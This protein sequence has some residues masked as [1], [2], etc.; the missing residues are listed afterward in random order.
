[1]RRVEGPVMAEEGGGGGGWGKS[2]SRPRKIYGEKK[3]TEKERTKRTGIQ[4]HKY[5]VP[6][7]TD[8]STQSNTNIQ[9]HI[10]TKILRQKRTDKVNTFIIDNGV[11]GVSPSPRQ[12][13]S[14]HGREMGSRRIRGRSRGRS[15][16]RGRPETFKERGEEVKVR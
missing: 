14:I 16:G 7:Q 12:I 8:T 4:I 11:P 10:Q 9:T 15:R 6:R 1:M 13:Q 3:K 5:T 2:K